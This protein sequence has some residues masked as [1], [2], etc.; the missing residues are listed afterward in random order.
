MRWLLNALTHY[1]LRVAIVWSSVGEGAARFDPWNG[2]G[3]VLICTDKSG[4]AT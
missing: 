3:G 2:V 1:Q 4:V